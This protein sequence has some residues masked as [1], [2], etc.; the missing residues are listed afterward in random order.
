MFNTK[1]TLNTE[2]VGEAKRYDEY[3]KTGMIYC[4]SCR[5]VWVMEGTDSLQF[6]SLTKYSADFS[7]PSCPFCDP[8]FDGGRKGSHEMFSSIEKRL[9]FIAHDL[10][11]SCRE[12]AIPLNVAR[13]TVQRFI[14]NP[15]ENRRKLSVNPRL[16]RECLK[17]II[18]DNDKVI[19]ERKVAKKVNFSLENLQYFRKMEY[20][21]PGVFLMPKA[22]R[23]YYNSEKVFMVLK[24]Y[25]EQLRERP[26]YSEVSIDK[27]YPR[28]MQQLK[29]EATKMLDKDEKEKAKKEKA[30]K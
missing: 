16:H 1:M 11:I 12:I 14:N 10:G 25:E 6:D 23:Y 9:I 18:I 29:K 15:L 24:Y 20:Y 27:G 21:P 2:I 7:K 13:Q 26:D 19:T 30:G 4:T 17:E 28:M 5:K 8:E 22:P 3:N